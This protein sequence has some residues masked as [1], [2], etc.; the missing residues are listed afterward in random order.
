MKSADQT[1]E[2][3]HSEVPN[4][5]PSDETSSELSDTDLD[6]VAGGIAWHLPDKPTSTPWDEISKI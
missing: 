6:S 5:G 2:G 1:P 4:Q 3:T